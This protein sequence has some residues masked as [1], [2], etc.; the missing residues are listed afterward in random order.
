MADRFGNLRKHFLS[1]VNGPEAM[2]FLVKADLVGA[3]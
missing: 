1:D 3:V 2:T